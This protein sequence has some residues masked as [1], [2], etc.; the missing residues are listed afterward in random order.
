M[1]PGP[2]AISLT[3]RMAD[4]KNI[5]PKNCHY[6]GVNSTERRR[7]KHKFLTPFVGSI[8]IGCTNKEL[9]YG[10]RVP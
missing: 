8:F 9:I 7:E 1:N 3:C 6:I 2:F 10:Y 4:D 5:A